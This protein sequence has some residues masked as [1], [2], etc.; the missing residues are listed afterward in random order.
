VADALVSCELDRHADR[1]I[2][3]ATEW[4]QRQHAGPLDFDDRKKYYR[5][6]LSRGFSHDQAM[7]ALDSL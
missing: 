6:L 4:L 3:L 1:W 7:D 5:R 2:D